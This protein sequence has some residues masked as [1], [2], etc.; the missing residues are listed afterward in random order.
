MRLLCL[1][2]YQCV[3]ALM[4]VSKFSKKTFGKYC[5]QAKCKLLS[6]TPGK[7]KDHSHL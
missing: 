7:K 6:Q 2:Y 3:S 5:P 1:E 4:S